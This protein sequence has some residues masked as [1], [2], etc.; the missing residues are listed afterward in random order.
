MSV[1]VFG[2]AWLHGSCTS[3]SGDGTSRPSG[4]VRRARSGG[5]FYNKTLCTARPGGQPRK[6]G[7]G[8]WVSL[9]IA[10]DLLMQTPATVYPMEPVM[11]ESRKLFSAA[12]LWCGCGR[13]WKERDPNGERVVGIGYVGMHA[14]VGSN[15]YNSLGF[16]VICTWDGP[17]LA[18]NCWRRGLGYVQCTYRYVAQVTPSTRAS[19]MMMEVMIKRFIIS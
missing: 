1:V 17:F 8:Y 10:S 18:F 3:T 12:W 11:K 9:L 6:I 2:K 19:K 4:A 16:Y 7:T 13:A 14:W 5:W 15:R